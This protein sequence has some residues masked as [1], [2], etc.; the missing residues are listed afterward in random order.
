MRHLGVFETFPKVLKMSDNT[1][2]V[3]KGA[4][5]HP[6]QRRTVCKIQNGR[7]GLERCLLLDFKQ[8]LQNKFFDPSISSMRKGRD[9]EKNGKKMT[10]IRLLP[11]DLPNADQLECRHLVPKTR[12]EYF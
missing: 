9:G 1:S 11:A 7:R 10:F 3:A 5:A 4:L 8:L 6:L 2:L 12:P